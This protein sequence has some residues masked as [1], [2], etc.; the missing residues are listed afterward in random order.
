MVAV[1]HLLRT[2]QTDDPDAARAGDPTPISTSP[3]GPAVTPGCTC[4][5]RRRRW[6]VDG[7][8]AGCGNRVREVQ[9]MDV[10]RATL[11]SD[12]RCLLWRNE[13]GSSTHF[14]DGAPRRRPIRYGVCNPGGA[15]LLGCYGPRFLA[16]ECKTVRGSQSADQLSFERAVLSR[17]GVYALVRSE[18]A[19]TDLLRWL[20]AGAEQPLPQHLRGGGSQQTLAVPTP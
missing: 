9:I 6:D 11:I 15:D 4:T 13:I 16:V 12:P 3:R 18:A 14:P 1:L 5:P 8:C 2:A 17:G 7:T 10:V 20:Q 19:A